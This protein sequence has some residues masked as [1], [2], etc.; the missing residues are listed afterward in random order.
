[1]DD[2]VKYGVIGVFLAFTLG[3]A[4]IFERRLNGVYKEGHTRDKEL[5]FFKQRNADLEVKVETLEAEQSFL[6]TSMEELIEEIKLM[7][8]IPPV[9]EE[10]SQKIQNLD[11]QIKRL[12]SCPQ[13]WNKHGKSC[14][15]LNKRKLTWTDAD[16]FCRILSARLAEIGTK[17]ENDFI[18]NII[19]YDT[20][21]A[22]LGGVDTEK[23]GTWTWSFSQIPLT[24]QNW[25]QGEPNND[26]RNEYCLEILGTKYGRWNDYPCSNL[27][28]SVCEKDL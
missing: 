24:F 25:D 19:K 23:E 22:W 1:M 3:A 7:K 14:Y 8:L 27:M 13:A 20:D 5:S 6:K 11:T 2:T 28:A 12:T 17:S 16:Q 4:Y 9:N 15:M 21:R 18:Y 10:V 26:N